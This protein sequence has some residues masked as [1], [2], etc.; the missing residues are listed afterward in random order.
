[1]SDNSA[2]MVHLAGKPKGTAATRQRHQF[3][4]GYG[5]NGMTFG[6]LAATLLRE[7]DG[8]RRVSD[9]GLFAFDRARSASKAKRPA[10]G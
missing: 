3:A 1:M 8:G 6:F 4:L 9:L 10:G 5:G 7:Q 2:L